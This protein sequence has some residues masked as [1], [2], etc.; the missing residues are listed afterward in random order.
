M[1]WLQA[2]GYGMQVMGAYNK[3]KSAGEND[4]LNAAMSRSRGLRN[5]AS[6]RREGRKH[7]GRMRVAIAKS[8]FRSTG[9]VMEE[10]YRTAGD[11]ETNA[12]ELLLTANQTAY[13]YDVS[14]SNAKSKAKGELASSLFKAYSSYSSMSG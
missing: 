13:S 11:I 5:A 4:R 10:L 2:I 1:G 14:A 12:Q 7:L 9:S 3:Y 8:G 6:K